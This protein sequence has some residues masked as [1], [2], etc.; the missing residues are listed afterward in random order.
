MGSRESFFSAVLSVPIHSRMR[1]VPAKDRDNLKF[2][3][4]SIKGRVR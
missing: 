3:A 1:L 4:S 2:F